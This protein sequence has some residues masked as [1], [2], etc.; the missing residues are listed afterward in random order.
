MTTTPSS[1]VNIMIRAAEKASRRL[2]RD[3]GE[4]ENLQVSKKGPG[5]FVS[6]ADTMAEQ[7]LREELLKARPEFGFLG[8]ESGA[9]K[10][11]INSRFIVDPI[12]GTTNFIHGIPHFCISIAAEIEG[13]IKA[14]VILD[15]IK[16]ELFWGERGMGAFCNGKRLRVAGRSSLEDAILA[17][18]RPFGH[19]NIPECNEFLNKILG[20]VAGLRRFGSA[21]LDLAYVAMGRL[22]MYYEVNLKPWDIAAG[23]L[24]VEEAK[25]IVT[26]AGGTATPLP[27]TSILAAN[28][29]LHALLRQYLGQ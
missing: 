20:Q 16:H 14:G 10:G 22:D 13:Q 8:E 29:T 9:T 3:F 18:G 15:P 26:E 5:D 24:L 25:G 2:V 11:K 6:R 23:V 27:T 7:T 19:E 17:V 21:A 4:I 1:L 28:P 12:D